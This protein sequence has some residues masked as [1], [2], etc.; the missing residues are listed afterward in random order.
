MERIALAFRLDGWP[1]E[2]GYEGI[3]LQLL[4]G[5]YSCAVVGLGDGKLRFVCA[6]QTECQGIPLQLWLLA[7]AL[8]DEDFIVL[9]QGVGR[10]AAALEREAPRRVGAEG[11]VGVRA[12]GPITQDRY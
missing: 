6:E 8:D 1:R 3:P 9:V 5:R 12:V 11:V 10:R 7:P 2:T 4:A